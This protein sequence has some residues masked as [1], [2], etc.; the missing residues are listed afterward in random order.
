VWGILWDDIEAIY[1]GDA[2]LVRFDVLR[3]LKD[4]GIAVRVPRR[5]A[6][7]NQTEKPHFKGEDLSIMRRTSVLLEV[8]LLVY[9]VEEEEV[10]AGEGEDDEALP[11]VEDVD[12]EERAAA[13]LEA[14]DEMF[15]DVHVL[16]PAV[17]AERVAGMRQSRLDRMCTLIETTF[18]MHT[19]V[20]SDAYEDTPDGRK[21]HASAIRAASVAWVTELDRESDRPIVSQYKTIALEVMPRMV[22][23]HGHRLVRANEQWQERLVQQ[24]KRAFKLTN[25]RKNLL[26]YKRKLAGGR[27]VTVQ[28]KATAAAQALTRLSSVMWAEAAFANDVR[29]VA[30]RAQRAENEWKAKSAEDTSLSGGCA[31]GEGGGGRGQR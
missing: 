28:P 18:K 16:E 24:G 17:I 11:M 15:D 8:V 1:K 9:G 30:K 21:D 7:E 25:G 31:E 4:A 5:R 23:F 14:E 29:I 12:L 27:I 20:H 26:A 13:Q 19:L 10:D 22:E 6:R 2:A 3:K